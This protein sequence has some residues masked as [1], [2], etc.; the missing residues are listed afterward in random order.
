MKPTRERETINDRLE[1]PLGIIPLDTNEAI[2]A[3][4][5]VF[6]VSVRAQA[7]SFSA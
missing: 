2:Q 6:A 7:G 4:L 1:I 3:G 5:N